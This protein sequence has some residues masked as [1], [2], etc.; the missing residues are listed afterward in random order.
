VVVDAQGE[1]YFSLAVDRRG[2]PHLAASVFGYGISL[3][4]ITRKGTAWVVQTV[5]SNRNSGWKPSIAL[6]P[7]GKP[8]ISYYDLI[9]DD[10]KIA[11]QLD[12][13]FLPMVKR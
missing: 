2:N 6:S 1:E 3:H 5:D 7:T 9:N 10:L 4:Y 12:Q 13:I 8:R 11:F